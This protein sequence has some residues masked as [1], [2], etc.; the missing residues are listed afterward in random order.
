MSGDQSIRVDATDDPHQA[1]ATCEPFLERDP[2]HH[3]VA[4]TVLHDRVAAPRPG[5]YWWATDHG[6]IVGYA[7]QSPAIMPAGVVPTSTAAAHAL[8]ERMLADAPDLPG[9]VGDAATAAALTGHW[10]ELTGGGAHPHEGERIY[11]LE[12]V[13]PVPVPPG[14]SGLASAAD[15]ETI[16]PW[17][18]DFH[19][20]TGDVLPPDLDV[21]VGRAVDARRMSLWIDAGEPVALAR[22]TGPVGGVTRVG[23]VFTPPARRGHGYATA[24]VAEVSQRAL[25]DGAD[26]CMLFTQLG[27]PTS[28]AIYRRIGYRA[29]GEVIAYRFD[30]AHELGRSVGA[31]GRNRTSASSLGERC[32]I[33]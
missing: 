18:V 12:Q 31:P 28:N 15:L 26:R 21:V 2:V 8:A 27:N 16:V 14:S 6:A 10:T 17:L 22:L 9:V 25:E 29:V 13:D 33:H 7:W 24:L 23:P 5:R 32:S 30:P 3:N 1:L 4:L 11:C 19:V 20:E